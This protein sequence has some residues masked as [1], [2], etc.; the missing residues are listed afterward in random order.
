MNL[1]GGRR[2]SKIYFPG[3]FILILGM[4]VCSNDVSGQFYN[5]MQMGFGKNRVQFKEFQWTYY[6]YD[7]FD[8]Y[9]YLGGK[10]LALYTAK[11][12][13][14]SLEN[15][16][17]KLDTSLDDKMQ[18]IVYNTL[19]DLKQSNIGL[20]QNETYN[21]GGVTHIVGKKI[22]LYFDG[23]HENLNRQIKAG[24]GQTIV[25]Q[26]LYGSS[27][28]SQIKNTSLFPF[29]DWYMNGLVSYISEEWNAEIEN[30][31][32]EGVL[33]GA[34]NK[35][36]RLTGEEATYAGHALWHYIAE[37]HGESSISN[38]VYMA[39][40]SRRLESGFLYILG[41]SFK[42][43][44]EEALNYYREQYEGQDNEENLPD[45]YIQ[46][47]VKEKV[48]YDQLKLSPEGTYAAYTYNRSGK[49][50]VYLK[51]Q[52][53]GKRTKVLKKGYRL[54]EKVDYS[55]PL[56][57]W[58]P[59][60]RILAMMIERKGEPRMLYYL[61]D[62]NMA[63][64]VIMYQF[65]KILDFAY[66]DDGLKMVMSA[67]IKGQTD[68]FVYDI[69]SN[70]FEQITKDHYDDLYPRFINNS[71]DIVFSSN[72]TSDT[73]RMERKYK[74]EKVQDRYD[75]F[76]YRYNRESNILRRVTNTPLANEIQAMQYE[77]GYIS[78]LSDRNGI[79]NR[80][81][82]WFDST[83]SY[84]DTTTHYRYFTN[85]F[86]ITDYPRNIDM[87]DFAPDIGKYGQVVHD[88]RKHL[89]QI[90]DI[91]PFSSLPK[92]SPSNSFYM[93]QLINLYG[94]SRSAE[95]EKPKTGSKPGRL[96]RGFKTVRQSDAI[97]ELMQSDTLK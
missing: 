48:V 80:Y 58:H 27:I 66:S 84:I 33:S 38:I 89:L 37:K 31:V 39:K 82:G 9:F 14:E 60:G 26:L 23:N 8:V 59:S 92:L 52:I 36:N 54:D 42:N 29:P 24:I 5:G 20:V 87:H 74:P 57:A 72:R 96:K 12:V 88:G 85:S 62:E 75:I 18:F 95:G 25:N 45:E 67:V 61:L 6:K 73:I 11:Y 68:I 16:E 7:N 81:V 47:K 46:K 78:F 70:S 44:V 55:Y 53:T 91:V 2:V 93:E 10:E 79:Y 77:P 35:F 41:I 76:M 21:T 63:E 19:S 65:E 30:H 49:Y 90:Y 13:E 71:S 86:A 94:E 43:L 40:V 28:G 15:I 1:F 17:D 4:L 51:D 56:I 97:R 69:G 22:F 50:K 3:V 83:I 34:Y 64:E 32:K